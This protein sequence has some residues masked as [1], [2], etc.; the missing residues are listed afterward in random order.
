MDNNVIALEKILGSLRQ[1][2][3]Y[4]NS[5]KCSDFIDTSG[6]LQQSIY[7]LVGLIMGNTMKID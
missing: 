7:F 1:V 3:F 5:H 6:F 4:K 2:S